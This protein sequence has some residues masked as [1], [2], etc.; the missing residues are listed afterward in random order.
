M[1]NERELEL[2]HR[3]DEILHETMTLTANVVQ[4]LEQQQKLAFDT[5]ENL[6]NQNFLLSLAN[7]KMRLMNQ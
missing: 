7:D 5:Q 2:V 4:S 6:H 3:R 1:S